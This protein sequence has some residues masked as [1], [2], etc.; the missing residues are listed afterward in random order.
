MKRPALKRPAAKSRPL[1][2]ALHGILPAGSD[3]SLEAFRGAV[4]EALGQSAGEAHV[5][6]SS[7]DLA[8]RP[9]CE[10]HLL[11]LWGKPMA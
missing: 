4:Q 10:S 6:V 9:V 5:V 3:R 2:E 1:R 8:A 11:V 7:F